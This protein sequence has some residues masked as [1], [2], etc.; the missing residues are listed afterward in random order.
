MNVSVPH[1]FN[2]PAVFIFVGFPVRLAVI[3]HN[4]IRGALLTWHKSAWPVN[5]SCN[6]VDLFRSVQF[7][8]RA[9]N[10]SLLLYS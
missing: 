5:A 9:V 10:E 1:I 2:P 4:T 3:R 6:W 7:S 8:S